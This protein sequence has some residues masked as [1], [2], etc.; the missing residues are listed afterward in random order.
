MFPP[1][2]TKISRQALINDRYLSLRNYPKHA[3]DPSLVNGPQMVD[4][5][6][7]L[8]GQ[9]ALSRRKSRIKQPLTSSTRYRHYAYKR[10]ALVT[11]HF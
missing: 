1:T 11:N 6:K 9:S 10:K 4:Q 5:R 2:K 7:T 3:P 8:L